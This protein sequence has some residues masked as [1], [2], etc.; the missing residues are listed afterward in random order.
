MSN[1]SMRPAPVCKPEAEQE[2][3]VADS[4]THPNT[5]HIRADIAKYR[6]I[7]PTERDLLCPDWLF[8]IDPRATVNV[9]ILNPFRCHKM[10]IDRESPRSGNNYR[11]IYHHP[12]G[13]T[14]S[15]KV[16]PKE[17]HFLRDLSDAEGDFIEINHFKRS[18]GESRKPVSQ[19][20]QNGFVIGTIPRK[21]GEHDA[22]WALFGNVIFEPPIKLLQ[23]TQPVTAHIP[24]LPKAKHIHDEEKQRKRV[25]QD[26]NDNSQLDR[27]CKQ[28]NLFK[29]KCQ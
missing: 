24:S 13:R 6:L 29:E 18:R 27:L 11:V 19:L 14:F 15:V 3:Y 4:H 26:A 12:D 2:A 1:E 5:A 8:E 25:K 22:A 17:M 7:K 23:E 16:S 10:Q 28:I 9:D 21:K 20:R